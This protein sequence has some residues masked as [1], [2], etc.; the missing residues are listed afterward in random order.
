MNSMV[1]QLSK[2][3]QAYKVDPKT[4]AGAQEVRALLTEPRTDKDPR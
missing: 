2:H 4:I 3:P 1:T